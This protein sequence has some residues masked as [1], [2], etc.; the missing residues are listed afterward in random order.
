MNR[1]VAQFSQVDRNGNLPG[2][3]TLNISNDTF[4]AFFS[5]LNELEV[6]YLAI[7]NLAG[8]YHGYP[9]ACGGVEL[10]LAH[11]DENIKKIQYL[12]HFDS[13]L[14]TC[15]KGQ[16]ITFN[17]ENFKLVT[18]LRL[19]HYNQLEFYRCYAESE[20]AIV[21]NT[22]IPVLGMEDFI[23]EIVSSSRSE[24]QK[25]IEALVNDN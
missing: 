2:E 17:Q 9:R 19:L 5:R 16:W 4:A 24:D 25:M 14:N 15:E 13:L 20:T 21:L 11:E 10:W 12:L 18:W 23:R 3:G 8:A 7:G 1:I 22:K 6:R